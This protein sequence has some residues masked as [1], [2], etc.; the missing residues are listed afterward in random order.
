MSVAAFACAISQA[1]S[2][3]QSARVLKS[4]CERV[5]TCATLSLPKRVAPGSSR[6]A[7]DCEPKHSQQGSVMP[8]WAVWTVRAISQCASVSEHDNCGARIISFKQMRGLAAPREQ[9]VCWSGFRRTHRPCSNRMHLRGAE[10]SKY[11]H[12]VPSPCLRVWVKPSFL[13][14][15]IL[16]FGCTSILM[17]IQSVTCSHMCSLSPRF[18]QSAA[19]LKG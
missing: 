18:R 15:L 10:S 11:G 8:S 3:Q 9:R 16:N 14:Y 13:L 4:A 2:A 1:L 5:Q 6:R 17:R 19:P 12:S 7:A